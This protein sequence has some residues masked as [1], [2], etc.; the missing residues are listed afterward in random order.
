[1]G[2]FRE[3]ITG[4]D[5]FCFGGLR[6]RTPGPPPFSSM[7]STPACAA[8]SQTYDFSEEN[9]VRFARFPVF[10]FEPQVT[11]FDEA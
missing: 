9:W 2:S 7:N 10:V 4:S 3:N 1:M 11:N 6:S 5:C 8:N